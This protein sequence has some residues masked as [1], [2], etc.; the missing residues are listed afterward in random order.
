[1]CVAILE[2]GRLLQAR[3]SPSL[4]TEISYL[5][6]KVQYVVDQGF[7]ECVGHQGAAGGSM[8][9]NMY[10][11]ITCLFKLPSNLLDDVL[12]KFCR[13]FCDLLMAAMSLA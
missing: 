3:Y 9:Q 11:N 8:K 7:S 1:M 6:F 12:I 13:S 10:V 2:N 4:H 5:S